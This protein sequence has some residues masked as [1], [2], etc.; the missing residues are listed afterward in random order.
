MISNQPP[1]MLVVAPHPDDEILGVG[2]TMARFVRAGGEVTVL[3][4]SAHMPPLFTPETH[5]QT[6]A[7]AQ[8]AHAIIGVKE[9]VFLEYPAVLLQEQ[10]LLEFNNRVL[11]ITQ[12]IKP[13]VMLIPYYDLHI[14]HRYVFNTAM[15][16]ARPVGV[17]RHIKFLAAYETISE[18]HWNAP[19][20]DPNFTPNSY[21]DI[22]EFIDQ[23]LE[24]MACYQS[25]LYPFPE[26]R[27]L[28]ALRALALL[29]G[30]QI[31]VGYAEGLHIIRMTASPEQ[32]F[33]NRYT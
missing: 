26:P 3:T 11:K 16:V 28:E 22:S 33:S 27:S 6:I 1:Q 29:R 10:S 19:H 15:F 14:D 4:V 12:E 2:G 18:T 30:S 23:K 32:L 8:A 24:A 31:G 7:E 20:L 13:D 5:V 25:Q 21:V 9:S 17:G